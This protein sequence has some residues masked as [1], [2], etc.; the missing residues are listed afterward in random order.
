M[1]VLIVSDQ[2]TEVAKMVSKKINQTGNQ[3]IIHQSFSTAAAETLVW[4]P[5]IATVDEDVF[6]L[7]DAIDQHKI[8]PTKI[9]MLAVAG[10]NDEVNP[11]KLEQRFGHQFGD[12]ILAY[13]YAVKMID[14]LELPYTII[15]AAQVVA[16]KTTSVI[17]NEG[18]PVQGTKIGAAVLVD[19]IVSAA[20]TDQYL[21]QS[22]GIADD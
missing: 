15:R 10:I 4:L 6:N 17:S 20:L 1:R 18:Q 19:L 3:S 22:I 14:E 8:T 16:D 13:Q 11:E 12:T 5:T 21:N 7:V 9:V 2:S